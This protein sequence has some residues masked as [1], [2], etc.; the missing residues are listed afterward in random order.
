MSLISVN[1]PITGTAGAYQNIFPASKRLDFTMTRI[2]QSIS[3]IS[4]GTGGFVNIQT[5]ADMTGVEIG[6]YVSWGSDAYSARNSR[7]FNIN[8]LKEI[9]VEEVFTSLVATNGF[10][11][12][13]KNW[14]LEIRYVSEN[15]TFGDQNAVPIMAFNSQVPNSV[16]GSIVANIAVPLRI[17]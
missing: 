16:D 3:S 13:K 6:D 9:E 1:Y 8:S 15:T 2:D 4:S 17:V 5:T 14:Y 11:N 10:I 7:V 12:Y